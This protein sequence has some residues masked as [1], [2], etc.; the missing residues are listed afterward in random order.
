[1]RG[2][3]GSV[4]LDPE[5]EYIVNAVKPSIEKAKNSDGELWHIATKVHIQSVRE[6]LAQVPVLANAIHIGNLEIV[7][8]WYDLETGAV[9]IL[10]S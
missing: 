6:Q 4:N 3:K 8:G 5:L 7:V 10:K 1:L 9:E 2:D